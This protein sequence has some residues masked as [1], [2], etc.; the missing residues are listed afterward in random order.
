[1]MIFG[2][3]IAVL[4][5]GLLP[6]AAEAADAP[7]LAT[8]TP[9]GKVIAPGDLLRTTRMYGGWSLNCEIL[10]SNKTHLCAVEQGILFDGRR[11]LNWSIA[12][13]ADNQPV[14][15]VWIAQATSESETKIS[16]GELAL[17]RKPTIC[18]PMG[19]QVIIPFDAPLQAAVFKQKN[20]VFQLNFAGKDITVAGVVDGLGEAL[21]AAKDDPVGLR[22]FMP[23][24]A[25][26]AEKSAEAS[27]KSS[28]PKA[29][30]NA[31]QKEKDGEAGS[32]PQ[33]Q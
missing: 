29:R 3:L 22:A 25:A 4:L 21:T 15:V 9:P 7:V 28:K 8:L 24:R 12:L 6:F 31:S 33:P 23:S 11:G 20:I 13:A 17:V 19:C 30:R 27:A 32:Q 2:R 14:L 26:D 16:V 5:F 18:D 10:L 1:M